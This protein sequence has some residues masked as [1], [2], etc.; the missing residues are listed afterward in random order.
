MK[1]LFYL[2]LT[3]L[4]LVSCKEEA[5][6][7]FETVSTQKKV[8]LFP[9]KADTVPY[10]TLDFKFVFPKTFDGNKE[11]LKTLQ[12]IFI[13]QF[14]DKDY[15]KYSPQEAVDA[16]IEKF[17]KEYR[18]ENAG[19]YDGTPSYTF[20]HELTL[21]DSI[22]FFNKNI[23]SF[24]QEYYEYRGG[25]HG[26]YG[27]FL[28][29][30]DLQTLKALTFQDIFKT[31]KKS[32]I[33][34]LIR[35]KLLENIKEKNGDK[36]YFFDFDKIEPNDNLFITDKGVK[37]V[38][39]VYE[40]AS[41]AA[42]IF[43]ITLPY[44]E[45]ENLLQDNFKQRYNIS[46]TEQKV[47]KKETAANEL[48]PSVV[49][50]YIDYAEGKSLDAVPDCP[51]F[52]DN[53]KKAY[54]VFMQPYEK[55]GNGINLDF[56]PLLCCC[57]TD[58]LQV[59]TIKGNYVLYEG[60]KNKNLYLN[61]RL[62]V[63]DD[64]TL[65]D[66]L[67][68]INM[69]MIKG[70]L[71]K[72]LWREVEDCNSNFKFE[73]ALD[74]RETIDDTKNGYLSIWGDYP[75]CGCACS[76][77]VG[78]YK[79]QY[80]FYTFLKKSTGSCE[81]KHHIASNRLL[82]EVLPE[83]LGIKT[84]IPNADKLPA[85]DIA[86]FTLDAEIPRKGTDTKVSIKTLPLGMSYPSK[87]PFVYYSLKNSGNLF[88]VLITLA[89]DEKY[90]ELLGKLEHKKIT[91]LS[92]D[93]QAVI[94]ELQNQYAAETPLEKI[95]DNINEVKLIYDYYAQIEYNSLLLGW[96]RQRARFYIKKKYKAKQKMSFV[97]FLQKNRYWVPGC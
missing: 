68:M 95:Q 82:S 43:D 66:G 50:K 18:N 33:T 87:E 83:G 26:M 91:D 54:K 37:F 7:T 96:D 31:D 24:S 86:M 9:E 79:D 81:Y 72:A 88:G 53:F 61:A 29:S 73:D 48:D 42:G 47:A 92:N 52:T 10:A 69:P 75:T 78:A 94:K 16:Y 32:Q 70:T 64:K 46:G 90:R 30:I 21:S 65:I 44:G 40:V 58:G 14:F 67:G 23:L 3:I 5:K 76:S 12:Q 62:V 2:S 20:Q 8:L 56:D 57:G 41:Y 4:L 45:I 63:K 11:H 19:L 22:V 51:Y 15:I 1:N 34:T 89:K 93:E 97:E 85:S 71:K 39:N 25:A 27:N 28:K 38:Y 35:A 74:M 77:T 59:K 17:S 49:E 13:E 84:F 36:S 80:G 6:L 60:K 55:E